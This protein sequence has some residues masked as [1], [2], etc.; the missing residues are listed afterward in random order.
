MGG[1]DKRDRP[2][3]T[4]DEGRREAVAEEDSTQVKVEQMERESGGGGV[5]S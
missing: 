1:W 4:R 2:W 5:A 3:L